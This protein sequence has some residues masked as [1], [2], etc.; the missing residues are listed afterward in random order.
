MA[1]EKSTG[2]ETIVHKPRRHRGAD[3]EDK[4]SFSPDRL[5]NLHRALHDVCWLLDRGYSISPATELAGDRYQLTRRQ[6]MA[7]GRCACPTQDRDRRQDHCVSVSQ[8]QGQELWLDGFNVL[9]GVESALGGGVI[10]IGRD[11]CC[12]DLAGVYSNYHKVVETV[13]ALKA[14]GRMLTQL[15]VAR[16]CWWLDSPV[17]NSGR[18]KEIILEVATEANWPWRV[19]RVISPDHVL[20][21]ADKIISSSDHAILDRCQQWF[22]LARQVI[23]NQVPQARV[24]NLETEATDSISG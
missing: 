4:R 9:T 1:N 21:T 24:V 12:R 17:F 22:N 11:G 18:L 8:L 13:P 6:R 23:E 14:I 10:L 3:P 15:G 20:A 19:E 7:I 2:S 16:C 5:P